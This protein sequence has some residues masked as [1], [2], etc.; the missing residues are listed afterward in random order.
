LKKIYAISPWRVVHAFLCSFFDFAAWAF[1]TVVFMKYLFGANK[2]TRT[3]TDIV[4]FLSI[5][6]VAM[7]I[8][9]AYQS[10]YN[11][12]YSKRT[13][14]I[15]SYELNRSLFEKA[16]HVDLVCYENPEFYDKYTRAASE[17]AER[18]QSVLN[19]CSKTLSA[20]LSSIY[21]IY[22]IFSLNILAGIISFIPFI[23]NFV[24]GRYINKLEFKKNNEITPYKRRKA[25]ADR[26][27]YLQQYSKEIRLT[28]I[29]GVIKN[30]YQEGFDGVIRTVHKYF[31]KYFI[32]TSSQS[33]LQ[34]ALTFDG[35]W[36]FAAWLAMVNKTIQIGDFIVLSNAIVSATWMLIYLSDSIV[37]NNKNALFIGNYKSFIEHIPEIHE[38]QQ[39]LSIKKADILEI[40][41]VS[42]RYR[43][44]DDYVIRDVNMILKSGKRVVIVGHNGAGK[45]TLV[46]LI[47]RLYDPN[48]G[49]ILLNGINIKEYDLKEYRSLIGTVFQDFKMF[50][51]SAVENVAMDRI[52]TEKTR[53]KAK[54]AM[55]QSGA[56]EIFSDME[57]GIDTILTREFDENGAVLSGG[58]AQK[59]AA[60]RAF[61]KNAGILILDEPSS[62]LDPIAE[63]MMYETIMDMCKN[64]D[65]IKKIAVIISHRLSAAVSCDYIYMMENGSVI[66]E[67]THLALTKQKGA[68]SSMFENQAKSYQF[69]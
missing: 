10:W 4:I 7:L 68:Y 50:S 23:T 55:E 51:M 64:R 28:E 5:T 62:A 52:E 27:M 37:E 20:F 2:I 3:Y 35:M 48:E 43:E 69:D 34:W 17:T 25:Y 26:V 59:I 61:S 18:A 66:E 47:M 49:E 31:K 39:G 41:N 14:I 30:T 56:I 33:F 29:F 32:I 11:N 65:N 40:R 63:H 54:K 8:A 21:V 15:I 36:L 38:D 67:G 44:N 60:A 9:S 46:K 1:F 42:F 24:I 16:S 53:E 45:T 57:K 6:T 22:T 19:N 12:I 58:E 13:D